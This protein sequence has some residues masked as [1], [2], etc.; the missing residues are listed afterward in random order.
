VP[1]SLFRRKT[2]AYEGPVPTFDELHT[3]PEFARFA[4][5]FSVGNWADAEQELTRLPV[6]EAEYAIFLAAQLEDAHTLL[7]R[8]LEADPSSS[9]ARTALAMQNIFAGWAIRTDAAASD[10]SADQFAAFH[11][12]AA[13]AENLLT[14]VLAED[15]SFAPA[16]FVR[17]LS[18]R[19]VEVAPSE[20]QR[21]AAAHARLVPG[22]LTALQQTLQ[23]VLPQWFG[24]DDAATQFAR[25]AA[26]ACEPGS[27]GLAIVALRHLAR[28]SDLGGGTAGQRYLA[29]PDVSDQVITASKTFLDGDP[30]IRPVEVQAHSA[31]LM[32]L[33][34]SENNQAARPHLDALGTRAS[35]WP[36]TL[37]FNAG[38]ELTGLY[39]LVL[40]NSSEQVTT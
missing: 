30:G 10:V 16:W 8:A 7:E 34:L 12:R 6:D 29:A 18:A 24:S 28:W 2:P 26:A 38:A 1:I 37:A 11:T 14:N 22:D 9:W 3:M 35:A 15:P 21:R 4:D 13:K 36:W 19:A 5:F 39:A 20:L 25:D 40:A 23:Y 17:I 27:S 31:F 33:A 32:A